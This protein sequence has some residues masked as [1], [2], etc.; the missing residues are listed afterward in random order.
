MALHPS[1]SGDI[2]IRFLPGSST[3]FSNTSPELSP[4]TCHKGPAAPVSPFPAL[5][6]LQ[7]LNIFPCCPLFPPPPHT[8][9]KGRE[10]RGPRCHGEFNIC[11]LTDWISSLTLSNGAKPAFFSLPTV[12]F[13]L[14]LYKWC[15]S[16]NLCLK[17]SF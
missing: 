16:Q 14:N 13:K 12:S 17:S 3:A 11:V 9:D 6:E 7:H 10:D 5:P 15:F 4:L 8:G 1:P 2:V